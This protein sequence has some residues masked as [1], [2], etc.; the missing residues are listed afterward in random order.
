MSLPCSAPLQPRLHR[1]SSAAP[2]H[3]EDKADWAPLARARVARTRLPVAV[4]NYRLTSPQQP[5]QHP[6]HAADILQCIAFLASWPGPDTGTGTATA[7]AT[8]HP[9]GAPSALYVLG[10]SCSA[11]MLASILLDSAQPCLA[12]APQLLRLVRAAVLSEGIYDLDALCR[13]FPSYKA[14]FVANAF[15]DRPSYASFN[16]AEHPARL[17]GEHIRWLVLHSTGD[18]LVDRL[19]SETMYAHLVDVAG[20]AAGAGGVLRVEKSFDELTEG[21]NDLLSGEVYPR[22]VADFVLADM[23]ARI[24]EDGV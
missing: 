3:S 10:H 8:E 12:P 11:H 23:A 13:S 9:P 5:T 20:A 4:P 1:S 19:Q 16:V 14:W 21:H 2:L 6:D 18:T 7:T 15:G 17:G 22:L 24:T